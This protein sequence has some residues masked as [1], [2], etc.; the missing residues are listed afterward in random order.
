MQFKT[1]VIISVVAA[2]S[3]GGPI[4][5]GKQTTET[6]TVDKTAANPVPGTVQNSIPVTVQN[7]TT[8]VTIQNTPSVK[9]ADN[10]AF[11]PFSAVNSKTSGLPGDHISFDVPTGK[12]L[13]IEYVSAQ[14][15]LPNGQNAIFSVIVFNSDSTFSSFRLPRAAEGT[16]ESGDA[17]FTVGQSLRLYSSART[18][19]VEVVFERNNSAGQML[20]EASISGYLVD[21]P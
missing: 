7:P 1:L 5:E 14:A 10:P 3:F 18:E 17:I 21:I 19:S 16:D 13:V 20:L 9:S 6:V 12:R 2:A 15:R 8:A 11:Q 4:S